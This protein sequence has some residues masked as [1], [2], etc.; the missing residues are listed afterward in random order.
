MFFCSVYKELLV[1]LVLVR[2]GAYCG[3]AEM[4]QRGVWGV[5]MLGPQRH[6]Y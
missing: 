6:D 4:S 2:L 1:P 3:A 5:Y